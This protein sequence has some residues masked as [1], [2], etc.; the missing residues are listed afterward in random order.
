MNQTALLAKLKKPVDSPTLFAQ[1]TCYPK[2]FNC[3]WMRFKG[4]YNI[5]GELGKILSHNIYKSY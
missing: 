1:R 5:I 2:S 4:V 3:H